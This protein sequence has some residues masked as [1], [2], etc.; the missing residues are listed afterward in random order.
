MPA[1]FVEL[2]M[3]VIKEKK[4][5]SRVIIQ[6]FD[7]R[8][9]KYLH[10]KYPDIKTSL[11]IEDSEEKDFDVQLKELGFT[12]TYYSPNFTMVDEDLV[13]L[14]HDKGMKI[15]P[16]TVNETKDIKK[17]KKIGVDGLI[18]DFPDLLK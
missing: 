5:E 13:K 6:S 7:L 2:L 16:W 8:S 1:E 11:L 10:E 17:L 18:T 9:L 4:I 15:I 14:C 12:P 3:S